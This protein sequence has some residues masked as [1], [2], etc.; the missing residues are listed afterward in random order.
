V[1]S[2]VAALLTVLTCTLCA[3]SIK[4]GLPATVGFGNCIPFGCPGFFGTTTYQEVYESSA[5]SGVFDIG[6]IDFFSIQVPGGAPAIGNYNL[7]LSYTS[8]LPG[9]LD[10]TNPSSN[11][12][13][14]TQGFFDGS[15]PSL[16]GDMLSITGTPFIY[17][18]A[19]GDLL[20][21][22]AISG[23]G[24]GSI[25]FDFSQTQ[26]QTGRAF[27]GTHPG[28]NDEGGL[29]TQFD[30]PEVIPEPDLSPFLLTG[31]A[32]GLCYSRRKAKASR[33]SVA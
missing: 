12:G 17:D 23:G 13:T 33:C 6:T 10:L 26:S 9:G 14:R 1:K 3:S 18:P 27:F 15:L 31:I 20:L 19:I 11:I 24:N 30:T 21:T 25:A 5:F 2:R 8:K 4:V 16:S 29:V 28:G 7:T 22:V 32:T